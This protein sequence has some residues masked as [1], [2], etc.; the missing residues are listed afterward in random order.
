MVAV[1]SPDRRQEIDS[2]ARALGR[3]RPGPVE[4]AGEPSERLIVRGRANLID[5][6]RISWK[7]TGSACFSMILNASA[8]L[9]SS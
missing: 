3:K 7:S 9:P 5:G 6:R 2:L 8:T 1:R 4:N